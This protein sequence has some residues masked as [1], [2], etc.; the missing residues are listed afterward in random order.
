MHACGHDSHTAMLVSAVQLLYRHRDELPGTLKF[1][2][3]PGEEGH[4]GARRM[5]ED[6]L[7]DADPKPD[8]AFALHI[9][10]NFEAGT[11]ASRAGPLSAPVG[12]GQVQVWAR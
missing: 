9:F 5:I 8:A 10:P 7:L 3:Q 6:G 1:M 4:A 11:I 2:F 12:T